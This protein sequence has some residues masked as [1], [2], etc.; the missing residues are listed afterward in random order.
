MSSLKKGGMSTIK[1]HLPYHIMVKPIGPICNLDCKYCFYLEKE[2]LYPETHNF[3]MSDELLEKFVREYIE[4]Q[5]GPEISFAWQGGEPTLMGVDFFRK[6]VQFQDRFSNGRQIS[7]A[8]QTNGKLLNDAWCEFLAE[9][10][11]LVG[12]S[13]DGPR[14][15]H[16]RYRVD[17]GGK[18][19]FDR[20]MHGLEY[21][22][23]HSV[24][25]NTLTVVNRHNSQR[26]LEVYRFLKG[27][28]SKFHQF[29]PIVERLPDEEDKAI[30]LKL[31][32][33]PEA[34]HADTDVRV[35]EWTVVPRQFGEFLVKIFDEWVRADVGDIFV[36]MFDVALGNWMQVGSGL[37]IFAERC[38]R[39]LAMEHNGDLY[40]CDHYVYPRYRLGNVMDQS[41]GDMV[42][43]SCQR[44]FGN[45]KFDTLPAYCMECEV[46][47]A[48]NG[49][50]PKQ[51]FLQTP[52]GEPGLN[53]LCAGYKR[54][55][56]HIDP[57]MRTM[58]ELIA[59][60]RTPREI[61]VNS[62][63]AGTMAARERTSTGPEGPKKRGKSS[64]I[65]IPGQPH[66]RNAPCPC[67]SGKKFKNCCG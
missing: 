18:P 9:R 44:K 66:S 51:R 41:L 6:V 30:K 40:S 38:G 56:K 21:L 23:K 29:I 2:N 43:S 33:P 22:E 31:G 63:F 12:L 27:I 15:L 34:G 49:E 55:F 3:S 35:T 24:E 59:Q 54:F 60:N 10:N 1:S 46:R 13:V 5:D 28:G 20:V 58:A 26:P 61:M 7:N 45:D 52:T 4:S 11:F 53:Y 39:A 64:T 36:Q 67:G 32:E 42:N 14:E 16:D 17:K 57:C 50:C 8:F 47:F 19:T 48:C 37:C 62:E 25:F 65:I